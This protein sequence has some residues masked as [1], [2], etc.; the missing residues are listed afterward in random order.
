MCNIGYIWVTKCPGLGQVHNAT[1]L[2]QLQFVSLTGWLVETAR[3]GGWTFICGWPV[4]GRENSVLSPP[5]VP[6]LSSVLWGPVTSHSSK[7]ACSQ[8]LIFSSFLSTKFIFHIL[9]FVIFS[10]FIK[11]YTWCIY[12]YIYFMYTLML[13]K[14]NTCLFYLC[15]I[16]RHLLHKNIN[17]NHANQ[18]NLMCKITLGYIK[19]VIKL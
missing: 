15:M 1:T 17:K 8:G 14:Y 13:L 7:L 5:G 9:Y 2:S 4:L 18:G 3:H 11:L 6:W 10:M 12:M 19:I 16:W